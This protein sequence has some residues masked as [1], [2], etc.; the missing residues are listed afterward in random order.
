MLPSGPA[1]ADHEVEESGHVFGI[2]DKQDPDPFGIHALEQ[3][4]L[5]VKDAATHSDA[6]EEEFEF[7][8]SEKSP[9]YTTYNKVANEKLEKEKTKILRKVPPPYEG[10]RTT[11]ATRESV[12][13][14]EPRGS[15][16]VGTQTIES[17][18]LDRAI[19]I[20]AIPLDAELQNSDAVPKKAPPTLPPRASVQVQPIQME[21]NEEPASTRPRDEVEPLV[22]DST[23][24]S[25]DLPVRES[26][27]ET[28]ASETAATIESNGDIGDQKFD[29]VQEVQSTKDE[30][31]VPGGFD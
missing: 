31:H 18:P 19:T 15:L 24:Q 16:D 11:T 27:P 22:K 23:E 29:E 21:D 5:K 25:K 3:E 8:P 9:I 28:A 1:P 6:P 2:P 30:H 10:P 20:T 4:G 14:G 7:H 17:D 12:D 13:L 26:H